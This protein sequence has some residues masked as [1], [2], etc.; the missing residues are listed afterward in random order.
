M[1]G[2]DSKLGRKLR[3]EVLSQSSVRPSLVSISKFLEREPSTDAF[4]KSISIKKK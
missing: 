1:H 4:I 3:D 2:Y